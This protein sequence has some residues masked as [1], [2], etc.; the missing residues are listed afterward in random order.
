MIKKVT[1][2]L[3]AMAILT[4]SVAALAAEATDETSVPMHQMEQKEIETLELSLEGAIGLA[5][6]NNP[7]IQAADSAIT[8]STLSLEVTA[9]KQK[10][11]DDYSKYLKV[12]VSDGMDVAYLKHGYYPFAAQKALDLAVMSKEQVIASIAYEV[13]EKY[14]NVKLMESLVSIAQAGLK[15]AEDNAKIINDNY[16]V[17]Y[18]SALEVRN[19]ENAVA[20]AEFS[21]QSYERSLQIATDSLRL[22]L[23]I[24][25][26]DCNLVL[27]DE[28]VLPELPEN[29]DEMI[30]GAVNTRYDMNALKVDYDL[31][32]EAFNITKFY[33]N[34]KTA[35]Y[36][37]AYSDYV[38]SKATYDNATK[39][40]VLALNNEYAGILTAKDNVTV[41][42]NNLSVA[43]DAY[44][45]AKTK[46]DMGMI[47]N[48]ELTNYMVQLD[49]SRVELENAK[50]TYLLAV[51]K[52]AY[53]TT[54][55]L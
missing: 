33:V 24:D 29:V 52:F 6:E 19:A 31:K 34:E 42:E 18:V 45:V 38:N 11:Y 51:E 21:V 55:G 27:T 35:L 1:A 26:S 49:Q 40:I 2:A 37:S 53:N 47:T 5:L 39:G 41:A 10:T 8:S 4:S 17:G 22:S 20:Q 15:M 9:E 13:T 14:Y 3:T 28:I 30:A 12:S 36:H 25:S 48:L 7:R 43:I 16:Q 23:Q 32:T 50:V 46:F 44:E 54:I